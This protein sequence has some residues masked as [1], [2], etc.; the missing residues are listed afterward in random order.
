MRR[1]RESAAGDLLEF[2]KPVFAFVS[3][4]W[5]HS[6]LLTCPKFG[7]CLGISGG[8]HPIFIK[9]VLAY[10]QVVTRETFTRFSSWKAGTTLDVRR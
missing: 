7:Y 3:K 9:L 8:A 10:K 6:R 5:D 4:S 1:G 2:I